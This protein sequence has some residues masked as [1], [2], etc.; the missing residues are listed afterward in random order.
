MKSSGNGERVTCL[1]NL[2]KTVKSEVPFVRDKG[3][4][5]RLIDSPMTTVEAIDSDV[6]RLIEKYESRIDSGG[7]SVTMGEMGD[8]KVDIN[9]KERGEA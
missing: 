4:D 8:F 3:L 9:A 6:T 1:N 5:A 7:I 2:L